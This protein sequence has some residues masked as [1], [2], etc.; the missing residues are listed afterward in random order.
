MVGA[1][2]AFERMSDRRWLMKGGDDL[3]LDGED[4]V[5]NVEQNWLA[6]VVWIRTDAY[7]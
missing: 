4:V 2:G 3:H 7:A 5:G 1:K 6:D